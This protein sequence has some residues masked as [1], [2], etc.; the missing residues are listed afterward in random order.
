MAKPTT[1]FEPKTRR[2]LFITKRTDR[3]LQYFSAHRNLPASDIVEY[4]LREKIP[5]RFFDMAT[6]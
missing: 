1:I 4:A 3:A 5:R 6:D 2:N